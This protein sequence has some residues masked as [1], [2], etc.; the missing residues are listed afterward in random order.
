[1]RTRAAVVSVVI[2][3]LALSG[4]GAGDQAAP[5]ASG[6]GE[7]TV[8]DLG[9]QD[10]RQVIEQLETMPVEQRPTDLTASIRPDALVLTGADGQETS[11]PMPEDE[12]YVSI[13]PYVDQ[14]HDCF[15]HSLTTCLG[16]M[17]DTDIDITV[18]DNSTGQVLVEKT[19]RTEDN[20][21]VGVWL[22]R[23]LDGTLT[24]EQGGRTATAPLGTNDDDPT[25]VTTVQL[26]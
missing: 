9:Q 25:C 2:A 4:C 26:A 8:A 24:I 20:G 23:D 3:V 13:A 15:F 7:L 16:E 22:P 6:S 17:R 18:T 11:L 5:T 12:F 21:F 19:T 1:M 14:T 10:A